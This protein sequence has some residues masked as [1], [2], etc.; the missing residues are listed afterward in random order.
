[1]SAA[2]KSTPVNNRTKKAAVKKAATKKAPA[3]KTT[4]KKT[5]AKKA[6]DYDA[7][8]FQAAHDVGYEEGLEEGRKEILNWLEKKYIGPEASARGSEEGNAILQLAG[9]AADHIRS[10]RKGKN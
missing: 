1:M 4:S 9:Q 6:V 3:K 10:L 2:K 7:E 8:K 5:P